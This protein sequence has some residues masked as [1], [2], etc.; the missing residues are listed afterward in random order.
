VDL[1]E[2]LR[3]DHKQ[4]LRQVRILVWVVLLVGAFSGLFVSRHT[5]ALDSLWG[6]CRAVGFA[7]AGVLS[8]VLIVHS[9]V[10]VVSELAAWRT[11]IGLMG[12]PPLHQCRRNWRLTTQSREYPRSKRWLYPAASVCCVAGAIAFHSWLLWL[13]AIVALCFLFHLNSQLA[14]PPFALVLASSS[15]QALTLQAVIRRFAIDLRIVSLLEMENNSEPF[16]QVRT[17]V[18]YTLRTR[19]DAHW[20]ELAHGL[21]RFVPVIVLDTRG[22]SPL[23]IEEIDYLLHDD[24]LY[25]TV[26]VVDDCDGSA[27]TSNSL[28]DQAGP[29][30][31]RLKGVPKEML[32]LEE[33]GNMP[34][35]IQAVTTARACIPSSQKPL[36]WIA[37]CARRILVP[38]AK[39]DGGESR[40]DP[41]D[42][43]GS[44]ADEETGAS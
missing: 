2:F 34:T 25:K 31:D 17:L 8:T 1:D 12:I 5:L 27:G 16:D 18:P 26:F 24:L 38:Q 37:D 10:L 21:M 33:A 4:Y 20:R 7:L 41:P 6:I 29:V 15:S 14:R 9:L 35:L 30:A 23:V 44:K 13:V 43:P 32:C 39:A 19:N 40:D 3:E 22:A 11:T 42:D 36:S 28:V